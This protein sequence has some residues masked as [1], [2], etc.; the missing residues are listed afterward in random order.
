MK[1]KSLLILV[2]MLIISMIPSFAF[3][4]DEVPGSTPETVSG[5]E[6]DTTESGQE[7]TASTPAKKPA[8]KKGWV[9]KNGKKY[10]YVNGKK[11]T[12][13]KKIKGDKYYF[14]S[15]GV[16]QTGMKVV[17]GKVY[18]LKHGVKTVREGWIK[19]K[20]IK[21]YGFSDGTFA[22]KPLK[23][24]NKVYMFKSNGQLVNKKGLFKYKGKYYY[25]LGKGKLKTGW[26]AEGKKAM[27]FNEKN[28]KKTGSLGSMARNTRV[29]HLK[30]PKG[31]KLGYAYALGVRQLDK[32]GWSLEKAYVFS[33]RLSYGGRWYRRATSEEYSIRG[34]TQGWGNCYVMA[35]TF[36]VMAK[37]LGY[38]V[39]QVEGRVDLPH[40][41]TVIKQNGT[42][43][44][45][46]P[47]FRNETG[48]NGW[49]I[50]Y[51]KRGTWRYN[52]FHKMN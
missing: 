13:W 5:Q 17:K 44:V 3:A 24:K 29:G 2:L 37:L 9:K 4:A 25:G 10:Y 16:M 40:S 1:K 47:N 6:A 51:G 18:Y 21:Y 30:I 15:Y 50:Y 7:K 19:Y 45:Y 28:S 14:N 23:I 42:E 46:D 38:D 22:N 20:G 31:G 43:W 34:F 35:A 48:R 8:V 11:V 33:Y 41:W 12:S 32:M 49:K 36:Y 26:V 52:S 39:H 27:Y